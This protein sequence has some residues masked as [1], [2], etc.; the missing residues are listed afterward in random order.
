MAADYSC[1]D[2]TKLDRFLTSISPRFSIY[3]YPLL[4]LGVTDCRDIPVLSDEILK[5]ECRI[6]NPVHRLKLMSALEGTFLFFYF[7][8]MIIF[9]CFLECRHIDDMEVAVLKKHIDVFISYRR[10]TGSQLASLLKVLLQ[11][12]GYKVN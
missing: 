10:S 2:G 6:T 8:T 5:K 9:F 11:L 4:E 12:R 1:V 3:T 7:L